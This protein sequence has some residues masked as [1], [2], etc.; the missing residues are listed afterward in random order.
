MEAAKNQ[1]PLVLGVLMIRITIC[2]GL[3]WGPVFMKTLIS[4]CWA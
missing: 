1:G 4:S 3:F 2:W